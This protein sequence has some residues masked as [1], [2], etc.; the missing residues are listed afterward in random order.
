MPHTG[1]VRRYQIGKVNRCSSSGLWLLAFQ[2]PISLFWHNGKQAMPRSFASSVYCMAS[3]DW[4]LT[5]T[6]PDKRARLLHRFI[7]RP[8]SQP[9]PF[10]YG[11]LSYSTART[12]AVRSHRPRC[13]IQR[14]ATTSLVFV[15]AKLLRKGWLFK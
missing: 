6:G 14:W 7:H 11:P 8:T 12:Q 5:I 3:I 9:D 1:P 10:T 2:G 4:C 15:R 13:P